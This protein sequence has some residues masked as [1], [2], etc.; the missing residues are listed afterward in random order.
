MFWRVFAEAGMQ[1]GAEVGELEDGDAAFVAEGVALATV[2][3]DVIP[4]GLAGGIQP[5]HEEDVVR[6]LSLKALHIIQ[7]LFKR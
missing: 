6:A 1:D 3:H 4:S 5:A 2:Y 7:F